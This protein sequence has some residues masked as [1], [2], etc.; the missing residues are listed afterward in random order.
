MRKGCLFGMYIGKILEQIIQGESSWLDAG[1][2]CLPEEPSNEVMSKD[3]IKEYFSEVA[4][5]YEI[6]SVDG[7]K[8][9]IR[10]RLQIV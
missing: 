5:N 9:Y 6:D 8:K 10:S 4:R 1:K 2:N 7:I 3:A